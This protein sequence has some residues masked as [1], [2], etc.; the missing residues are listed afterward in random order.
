MTVLGG[1]DSY[2]TTFEQTAEHKA[3]PKEQLVGL[4]A[5][6]LEPGPSQQSSVP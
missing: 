4:L 5:P 3:W 1:I 6:F 2:L